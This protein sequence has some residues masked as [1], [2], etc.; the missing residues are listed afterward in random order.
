[1]IYIKS[2]HHHNTVQVTQGWWSSQGLR[3]VRTRYQLPSGGWRLREN[4]TRPKPS[5][6][7]PSQKR[8]GGFSE[9][10]TGT[11]KATIFPKHP[12]PEVWPSPP[13]HSPWKNRTPS[14]GHRA[15]PW[16][17]AAPLCCI[18]TA[19]Q[20]LAH[21]FTAPGNHTGNAGSDAR[22]GGRET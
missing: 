20:M 3:K 19:L 4:K 12:R 16:L 6:F 18:P 11:G 15:Q 17:P 7:L 22:A 13:A 1:M 21:L 10:P 8:C 14:S 9:T 5:G 2:C